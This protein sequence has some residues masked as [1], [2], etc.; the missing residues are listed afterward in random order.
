MPMPVLRRKG[1][2]APPAQP[3]TARQGNIRH[4]FVVPWGDSAIPI[5]DEASGS[6]TDHVCSPAS[7]LMGNFKPF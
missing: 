7:K 1:G 4:P 2:I 5:T 6:K 3:Q